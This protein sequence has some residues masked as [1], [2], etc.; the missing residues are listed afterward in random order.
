[1]FS[2][3]V[4]KLIT[5]KT[6]SY[7]IQPFDRLIIELIFSLSVKRR[8]ANIITLNMKNTYF[9]KIFSAA[10]C[11]IG[12]NLVSNAQNKVSVG[13]LIDD[14]NAPRWHTDT[15]LFAAQARSMGATPEIRVADSDSKVQLEQAKELI[16]K[17][18][19]VIVLVP[20]DAKESKAVVDYAH[21]KKVT[22]IAYDRLVPDSDLDYYVAYDNEKI[23]ELQA[24]ALM[25]V[26][27]K[28][29]YILLNGPVSDNNAIVFRNG[30][31]KALKPAVDKGDI[32][33]VYDK[34][35]SEWTA[36]EAFMQFTEFMGGYSGKVAAVVAANDE[37]AQGA[38]DVLKTTDNTNVAISGQD[39]DKGALNNIKSGDQTMT[40]NKPIEKIAK[41]SASLAVKIAKGEAP[42]VKL[43]VISNGKTKVKYLRLDPEVI[44]SSNVGNYLK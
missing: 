35:L 17:G 28:G 26:H 31:L 7:F 32:K 1:M 27:P 18:V 43:D 24:Q 39:G 37:L 38:I 15:A 3:S 11:I 19:K 13:F 42:G 30:Q 25:K 4:I 40:V 20:T 8:D 22:V 16:G 6:T 33:I 41:N 44:D 12:L 2:K 36:L 14:F 5:G 21:S 23:G 9:L 29:D 10:V 34:Q